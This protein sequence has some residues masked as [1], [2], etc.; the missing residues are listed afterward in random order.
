MTAAVRNAILLRREEA[1]GVAGS[2]V[3]GINSQVDTAKRE[4]A[5]GCLPFKR[6]VELLS[7]AGKPQILRRAEALLGM[8]IQFRGDLSARL[9]CVLT[10]TG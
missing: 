9:K 6:A 5:S 2:L 8:T 1:A 3:V 10:R 4:G 7:A